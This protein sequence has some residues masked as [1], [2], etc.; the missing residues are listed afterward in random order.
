M[1]KMKADNILQIENNIRVIGEREYFKIKE[2]SIV[3]SI[4][5]KR[6]NPLISCY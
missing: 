4:R 5:D 2:L 1:R 6:L 3:K